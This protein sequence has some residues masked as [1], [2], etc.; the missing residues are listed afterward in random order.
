MGSNDY[1]S[2]V[3]AEY[4]KYRPTYPESFFDWLMDLCAER[5]LVWDCA[6]GSG[7]A[8]VSL[9]KRFERVIAT[10]LSEAQLL[11]GPNLENVE[12]RVA[13]ACESGIPDGVV[14]LVAVGQA[15][16]WFELPKFWRECQRVLKG[17]GIVAAFGYGIAE[18]SNSE[19][20]QAFL[21][22]YRGTLGEFWN[23]RRK[24]VEEGYVGLDFPFEEVRMPNFEICNHWDAEQICGYCSSWSA[25]ESYRQ[26]T[27]EDPIPELLERL[28]GIL[29]GGGVDV[30]WKMFGRVGMF[31]VE[32]KGR[33]ETPDL[34][35]SLDELKNRGGSREPSKPSL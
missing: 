6:C 20:Q 24:M 15:L 7:Q 16:H 21:E 31:R 29:K 26:K 30:K 27:G 5:G 14:D 25:M 12:W 2:E 18:F 17:R 28:D 10:D 4:V 35:I 9:S 11:N 1:F 3:A 23:P 8:T 32:Q 33:A 22:F 13:N 34:P 19:V